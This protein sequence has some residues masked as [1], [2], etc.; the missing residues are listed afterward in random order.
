[1]NLSKRHRVVVRRDNTICAGCQ[2]EFG[3]VDGHKSPYT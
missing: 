1:M 3:L 2:D